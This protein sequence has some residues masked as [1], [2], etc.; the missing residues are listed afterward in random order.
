MIA[1]K[2][3]E[4]RQFAD[5]IQAHYGILFKAEKKTMIAGRLAQVLSS[6]NFDSLSDYMKYV[7]SDKTGRAAS[8]MLDKITTN[9]TFFMR[10]PSH[11][12]YFR[13]KVLPYLTATVKDKDFRIWSAAC[14]SGEEPYTLAM[15]IDEFFGMN[16]AAW[17]AKIL[18]TDISSNV[19]S[20]AK[21]GVYSKE[22]IS[23]LPENWKQRYFKKQEGGSYILS[24]KI[25][26]E[27]IFSNINLMDSVFPFRKR[28]HVIFCRNVMI[29]FDNETKEKLAERLYDITEPGGF[30]FIGHS[31]SLNRERTRY[32]YLMPAVY[33][34]E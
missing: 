7:T 27:V 16:K 25:R 10:E 6:M 22:K 26:N 32:R 15:I 18:A 20:I 30:L 29:Y 28:M 1:I 33:R 31:E 19:L 9:H 34:K 24:E 5:F 3:Q 8:E 21:A 4:F 23:A 14:S 2:D 17:D 12:Y 11:F 13:D